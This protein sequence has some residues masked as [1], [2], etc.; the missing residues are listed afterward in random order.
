MCGALKFG[1]SSPYKRIGRQ[2][3]PISSNFTI[4]VECLHL[5]KILLTETK[6][7]E[8]LIS[9]KTDFKPA[10]EESSLQ[11]PGSVFDSSNQS[12]SFREPVYLQQASQP[13][14]D[15]VPKGCHTPELP[16]NTI[17]SRNA[18]ELISLAQAWVCSRLI[19]GILRRPKFAVL[20]WVLSKLWYM[21]I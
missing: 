4:S 12:T 16:N 1:Q 6:I 7:Y 17:L 2:W 9:I 21:L 18:R 15:S 5:L 13:L 11:T 8:K 14:S 3:L 10:S 19:M 20:D